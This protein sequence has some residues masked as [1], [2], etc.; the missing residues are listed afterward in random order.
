MNGIATYLL[1]GIC[2]VLRAAV[3]FLLGVDWIL[4]SAREVDI[5]VN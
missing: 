5:E 1:L 4:E 2:D 3:L